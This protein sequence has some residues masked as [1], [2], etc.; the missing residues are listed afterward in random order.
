MTS[1]ETL[2]RCSTRTSC[3]SP[4]QSGSRER[5]RVFAA[6]R[7]PPTSCWMASAPC[8]YRYMANNLLRVELKDSRAELGE[9][10]TWDILCRRC[11]G[12]RRKHPL[13]VG[14]PRCRGLA[15]PRHLR[16]F[17]VVPRV[18][19]HRVDLVATVHQAPLGH[20]E[21]AARVRSNRAMDSLE[22]TIQTSS[23]RCVG[24]SW[25]SSTSPTFS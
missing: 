16:T 15:A 14:R 2:Q 1:G 10:L 22:Y 18:A 19:G 12:N 24:P 23:R 11:R 21:R 6:V 3:T 7:R 25:K 8:Q 13:G 4:P 9:V 5:E 20:A 17:E